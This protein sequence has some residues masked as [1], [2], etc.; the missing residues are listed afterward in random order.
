[1]IQIETA[2]L[3]LRACS[4]ELAE[5]LAG[6]RGSAATMIGSPLPPGWPDAELLGFLPVY[7]QLL[8][9]DPTVIGYGIWLVIERVTGMVVGSA[10]FQG[11]PGTTGEIEL[12]F[13][14][15]PNQRNRGFAT[16]AVQALVRWGLEQ[17][18][19]MRIIAQSDPANA[20]SINVL[21]KSGFSISGHRS[22][23]TQWVIAIRS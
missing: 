10:G 15:E 8:R 20:A 11:Q 2:R 3:T 13:G 1:M 21:V 23:L 12:G 18:G 19:V 17:P 7:G 16:E 6:D 4:L 22:D 9:D 14:I 5:A